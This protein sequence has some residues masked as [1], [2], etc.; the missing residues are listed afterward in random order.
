AHGDTCCPLLLGSS[1]VG[2]FP[3]LAAVVAFI[4]DAVALDAEPGSRRADPHWFAFHTGFRVAL[5][6]LAGARPEVEITLVG[7]NEQSGPARDHDHRAAAGLAAILR[8]ADRLRRARAGGHVQ[9]G[10]WHAPRTGIDV[11]PF[12]IRRQADVAA[13]LFE[14]RAIV[15]RPGA[16]AVLRYQDASAVVH[17]H[18]IVVAENSELN[19]LQMI[20]QVDLADRAAVH[21]QDLC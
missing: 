20:G 11:S 9:D 19:C 16:T 4:G 5:P 21:D 7:E 12:F 14:H 10:T 2:C 3:D 1:A 6:A 8:R 13:R 17:N 15:L 18:E